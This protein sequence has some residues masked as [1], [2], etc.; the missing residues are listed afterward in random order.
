MANPEHPAEFNPSVIRGGGG[1]AT[2]P[3]SELC[4]VDACFSVE[5]GGRTFG[6][7]AE[8]W[9]Q[10]TRECGNFVRREGSRVVYRSPLDLTR[11]VN[12]G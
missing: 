6:G 1:D 9:E 3:D 4:W 5:I 8:F 7:S 12:N 2:A 10:F 11:L